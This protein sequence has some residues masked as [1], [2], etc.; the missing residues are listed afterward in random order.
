MSTSKENMQ[1]LQ[2]EFDLLEA[3]QQDV[4]GNFKRLE[5]AKKEKDAKQVMESL[6]DQLK[7]AIGMYDDVAKDMEEMYHDVRKNLGRREDGSVRKRPPLSPEEQEMTYELKA[8]LMKN[9]ETQ[10]QRLKSEISLHEKM[11]EAKSQSAQNK[12]TTE[13]ASLSKTNSLRLMKMFEKKAKDSETKLK[14]MQ[15]ELSK[16]QQLAKKYQQLYEMEKRKMGGGMEG[17]SITPI[18]MESDGRGTPKM[19]NQS[20][21]SFMGTGQR[22]NDII[23][24]TEVL[25]EENDVLKREIHRLKQ[26]NMTLIKKAKHA[27]TD[28]DGLL[29]RLETSEANRKQLYKRLDREKTQ[30]TML[31][32]SLTRQASDWIVLK[33]QLAQFDEEYRWSQAGNTK[34]KSSYVDLRKTYHTYHQGQREHAIVPSRGGKSQKGY[35]PPVSRMSSSIISSLHREKSSAADWVRI[36]ERP[37]REKSTLNIVLPKVKVSR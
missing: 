37:K 26:D 20:S 4:R 8:Q 10:N 34:V 31:S 17:P 19:P 29:T 5:A 15:S 14:D 21:Y 28:K 24:K 1:K 16:S 35:F 36:P 13:D 9:V 32:R 33:K 12:K 22:V 18:S 27:M 3:K 6:F 23:R 25:L 2:E 7:E 11:S 30:H